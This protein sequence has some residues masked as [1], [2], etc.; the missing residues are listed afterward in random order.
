MG[1]L[2]EFVPIFLPKSH[3][4]IGASNS[5]AKFG[6]MYF[7]SQIAFGYQG[8]LIPINRDETEV[9]GKKAYAKVTDYPGQ[10]D[11][12]SIFVPARAV[13]EVLEDCLKKGIPAVQII[14]AGFRELNE[15]GKR[16]EEQVKS[17]SARGIRVIGPNCFGVYSPKG[18]VTVMP[19]GDLPK[20]PGPVAFLSQSGGYAAR[21]P[22]RAEG[23]GIRFSKVCS[24]GNAS[25]INECD[26]LEYLYEDPDTQIITSYLE[27]VS[28][29]PRFLEILKKVCQKKPVIIWK[30][31]LTESGSHAVKSHTASLS[32]SSQ[33]W[34]AIFKQT[35]AVSIH[36]IDEL[37]DTVSAFLHLPPVKNNNVCVIGGGGGIGVA[38]ADACERA[39]VNLP[40]FSKETQQKLMLVAPA[41]GASV[42]NPIDIGSPFPQPKMLEG[43]MDIA[44]SEIN[45][46]AV[47]LDELEMTPVVRDGKSNPANDARFEPNK[48]IPIQ[49]KKKYN[50]A[51]I[52]VLPVEG[53][54]ADFINSEIARRGVVNSYQQ[55]GLPVFLSLERAVIAF[56]HFAEYWKFRMKTA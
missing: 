48:Q 35:G 42:R 49:M 16:L 24:Y 43:A 19:G 55:Q 28:N 4:V 30:G 3:A 31:G 7:R 26:L 5:P 6:G 22:R 36:S 44:L 2:D 11:F 54:G 12:A 1:I 47:I 51:V 27:G 32:G 33:V 10:I 23:L 52:M 21:I 14:T 39:S 56:S 15:E 25:D 9:N 8:E 40:V 18:G 13:P 37:L 17:I 46:D 34:E 53:N 20:E 41:Q 45:I 38:A 29:G 50:K